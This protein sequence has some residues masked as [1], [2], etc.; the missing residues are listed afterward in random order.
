MGSGL[1]RQTI[2]DLQFALQ[3]LLSE[4]SHDKFLIVCLDGQINCLYTNYIIYFD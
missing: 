4:N 1:F 2:Y 3:F